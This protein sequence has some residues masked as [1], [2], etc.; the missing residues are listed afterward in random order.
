ML[1][2]VFAICVELFKNLCFWIMLFVTP[3]LATMSR[4]NA[5]GR[6]AT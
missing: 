3:L 1:H 2:S 6:K 5:K 4:M